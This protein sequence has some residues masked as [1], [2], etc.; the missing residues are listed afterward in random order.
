MV[1]SY[2]V[3]STTGIVLNSACKTEFLSES[4]PVSDGPPGPEIDQCEFIKRVNE[5]YIVTKEKVISKDG[6]SPLIKHLFMHNFVGSTVHYA[7][8]TPENEQYLKTDYIASKAGELPVMVL[9][10]DK[11]QV[12]LKQAKFLHII[13]HSKQ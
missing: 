8:I 2:S 9:W 4:S 7:E 12:P 6:Q 11:A 1:T 13:L 5:H 3:G 10:L